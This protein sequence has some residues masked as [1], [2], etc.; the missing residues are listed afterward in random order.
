MGETTELPIVN[1]RG[2]KVAL[3]PVHEGLVPLIAAWYNDFATS[4]VSGDDLRPIS[5]AAVRAEWEALMRGERQGW[6]GFAVYELATLRPIGLANLRDLGSGH[7]TAEFGIL[8]GETDCRGKG[9][10][11]EATQ[12]VLDYAFTALGVHNVWL[13]TLSFN[14]AAIRAYTRAGFRE[15]GRRREA[16]WIGDRAY[17]VVLMDCLAT[18]FRRPRDADWGLA[19]IDPPRGIG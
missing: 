13:D 1:L 14:P 7:R 18:E 17:D 16:H 4:A 5:P 6:L 11:T 10:G 9:Y 2:D 15:I 19:G 3:G 8:I 12:L